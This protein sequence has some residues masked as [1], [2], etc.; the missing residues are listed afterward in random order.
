MSGSEMVSVEEADFVAKAFVG[1]VSAAYTISV[2]D[3]E[4]SD[5]TLVRDVFIEQL[6]R[7][8]QLHIQTG[9]LTPSQQSS[10]SV[11]I[12]LLAESLRGPMVDELW[13]VT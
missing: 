4:P 2:R 3:F 9:R 6:D 11:L 12:Q 10:L 13:E 7:I 1:F 8:F 5:R